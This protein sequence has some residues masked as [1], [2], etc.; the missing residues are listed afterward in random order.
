MTLELSHGLDD[1]ERNNM[2][3]GE[4]AKKVFSFIWILPFPLIFTKKNA[5]IFRT[6]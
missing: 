6:G 3:L 2:G 4:Y 5:L 1:L